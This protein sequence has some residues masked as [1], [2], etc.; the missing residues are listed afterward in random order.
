MKLIF[1]EEAERDSK[2]STPGGERLD[3]PRLFAEELTSAALGEICDIG[4]T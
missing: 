4:T 1:S 3:A 2:P